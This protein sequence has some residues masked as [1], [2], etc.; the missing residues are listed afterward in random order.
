VDPVHEDEVIVML[1]SLWSP[2]RI[3]RYLRFRYGEDTGITVADIQ[4]AK[5]QMAP[6][7]FIR[8]SKLAERGDIKIDTLMAMSRLLLAQEEQVCAATIALEQSP[9]EAAAHR[10]AAKLTKSYWD[11]LVEFSEVAQSV[12]ELPKIGTKRGEPA[13]GAAPGAIQQT[14]VLLSELKPKQ[15]TGGPLQ[16]LTS[17]EDDARDAGIIEGSYEE[18]VRRPTDVSVGNASP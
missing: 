9:G 16:A 11:M 13:D 18:I 1:R 2:A 12:G 7:A 8:P 5:D 15:I 4:K 6:G 14:V 10:T 17:P 3:V